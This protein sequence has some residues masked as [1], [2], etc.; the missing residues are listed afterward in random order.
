M[1]ERLILSN[2][3]R[4]LRL[5]LEQYQRLYEDLRQRVLDNLINNPPEHLEKKTLQ[6]MAYRG[7]FSVAFVSNRQIRILNRDWMGKDAPTDV[8]S[9]PLELEEPPLPDLPW[10]VGEVIISA[11]RAQEQAIEYQHTLER[12][13]C[14]LFVHGLLHVL[15]FDH[16]EPGDE[17]DMFSR[18]KEILHAAGIQR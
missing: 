10:E 17:K 14:F 16:M 4:R 6:S 12:E 2:R 3:Q 11:E 7:N 8:L 5:D 1:S 9:F 18:Q 15:G 13:L